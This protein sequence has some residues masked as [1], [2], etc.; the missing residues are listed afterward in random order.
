[1]WVSVEVAD[2]AEPGRTD[3]LKGVDLF[4]LLLE[5]GVHWLG[6]TGLSAWKRKKERGEKI[7]SITE[8]VSFERRET[9]ELGRDDHDME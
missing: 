9:F 4:D 6:Q 8:S 2:N 5:L 1:V 3:L 7:R